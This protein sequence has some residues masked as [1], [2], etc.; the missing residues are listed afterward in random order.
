MHNLFTDDDEYVPDTPLGRASLDKNVNSHGHKFLDL[1]KAT[2]L[3][4]ANGRLGTDSEGSH[5]F[6]KMHGSSVID[7]LLLKECEF[8]RIHNFS[9]EN[10]NEWSDHAPLTFVLQCITQDDPGVCITTCHVNGTPRTGKRF[11]TN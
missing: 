9:V 6:C 2:G 11:V 1:C 5:T 4:I 7:Y 10:F 8:S 3:R